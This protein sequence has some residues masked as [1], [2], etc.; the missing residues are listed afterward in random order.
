MLWMIVKS[1]PIPIHEI[2]RRMCIS[3]S[4]ASRHLKLLC[5]FGLIDFR[6]KPHE[7]FCFIKT[8]TLD[9]LLKA[10]EAVVREMKK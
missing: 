2:V 9:H 10:Y 6:S 7:K 1:Q 5:D 4:L 8:K 3:E